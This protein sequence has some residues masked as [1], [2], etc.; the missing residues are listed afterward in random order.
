VGRRLRE[1]LDLVL[2][3]QSEGSLLPEFPL[4]LG[5]LS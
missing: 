4:P 3:L 5:L 2:Q 1:E